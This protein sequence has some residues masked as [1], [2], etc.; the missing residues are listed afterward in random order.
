MND[1]PLW[2]REAEAAKARG[3]QARTR[4]ADDRARWIAKGVEEYGR[5]GRT[6]AA[7]LLGIS[8]GEVDKALA[9]ARGLARPTMLPDTDELLERLYALELATLPPLPATGWQVL[10]HIV[11]GTIVDV[12]WLCDPGELLAQEVDDLDPG[13]I[14]AGV[15]GVALAGACRAWSRTQA[16]AVI[17]ALAVGDLARLPAVNSP[18]GS[19]AR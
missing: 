14:P 5:G 1:T 8:V 3:E 6:R 18:A 15:D 7:E 12:T 16:L 13:E 19:A 10:A 11:R 4:A 17:D 2:L 9:R